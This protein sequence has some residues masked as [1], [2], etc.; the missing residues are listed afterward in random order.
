MRNEDSYGEMLMD[1]IGVSERSKID[2]TPSLSPTHPSFPQMKL[3]SRTKW[4]ICTCS[5]ILLG[6]F[7]RGSYRRLSRQRGQWEQ[8]VGMC[9]RLALFRDACV[10]HPHQ[11]VVSCP[12]RNR[13]VPGLYHFLPEGAE[14][15][16]VEVMCLVS[17]WKTFALMLTR[18]LAR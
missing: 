1:T 7:C 10:M 18:S 13:T 2:S 3:R 9:P 17:L 14:S 16:G 12:L 6:I 4:D 8:T 5:R 15:S 11:Y